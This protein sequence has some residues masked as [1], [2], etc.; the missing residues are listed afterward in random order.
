[1]KKLASLVV[2]FCFWGCRSDEPI[3]LLVGDWLWQESFSYGCFSNYKAVA[4]PGERSILRFSVH[5]RYAVF[6]N[7]TL[8]E[9]GVFRLEPTDNKETGK[10]ELRLTMVNDKQSTNSTVSFLWGQTI[11]E[12]TRTRLSL[13]INMGTS[14]SG[15]IYSRAR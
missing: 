8:K 13:G 1:M 2:L 3:P 15:S 6:K 14:W 5:N 11:N 12:L 10:K 7:D 4:K 9:E